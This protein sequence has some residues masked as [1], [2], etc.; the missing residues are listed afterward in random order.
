MQ[1]NNFGSEH[2]SIYHVENMMSLSDMRIMQPNQACFAKYCQT[3][4]D[5][6]NM[7]LK[8]V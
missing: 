4:Q 7:K 3:S 2:G 5:F 6:D 8:N 1:N